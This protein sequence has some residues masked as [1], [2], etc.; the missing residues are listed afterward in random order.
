MIPILQT[1][2]HCQV[3]CE[4]MTIMVGRSQ[5]VHLRVRQLELLRDCA[6]ICDCTQ[7]FIAR[8]S[9]FA[10]AIATLCA[11]VC[12]ICANECLKFPDADSQNCGHICINCARECRAF[13]AA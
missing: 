13:A 1:L 3:T 6:D 12:E 8:H 11:N 5:D 9:S 2:H 10:K 7:K 4:H